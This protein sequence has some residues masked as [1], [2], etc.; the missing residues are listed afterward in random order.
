VGDPGYGRILY[1]ASLPFDHTVEDFER[2]VGR[3]LGVHRS[4]FSAVQRA[5]LLETV[6]DD[7]A[8]YRASFVSI[9]PPAAWH[10]IADGTY[11]SWLD[12]LLKSLDD[13]GYPVLLCLHHEPEDD[14]GPIGMEPADWVAMQSR[15]ITLARD[16]PAVTIVPILMQWTFDS[17]SGRDPE[18]WMVAE[19]DVFGLD[20]YNHWSQTNGMEWQTFGSEVDLVI[21]WAQGKPILIAEYGCRDDPQQPG[22]AAQWIRDTY[23]YSGAH[24]IPLLSYFDSWQ[25]SP[26]GT[27]ELFGE[28]LDAF[29]SMLRASYDVHPV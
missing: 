4:Y 22:R 23:E 10:E 19:A 14:A 12:G 11:D 16:K 21:P 5:Q 6:R 26:D 20:V 9:K 13:T 17:R 7:R 18:Q 24:S 3:H 28:R 2:E 15:A 25:N 8:H 27:W 29:E 1:G